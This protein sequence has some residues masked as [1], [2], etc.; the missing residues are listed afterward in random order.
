MGIQDR[1]ETI[2]RLVAAVPSRA[3]VFERLGIDYC[4]G[5]H[6]HLD[7]VAR[8]RGIDLDALVRDVEAADGEPREGAD[9]RVASDEAL[10]A[11]ILDVHHRYLQAELP[12]LGALVH[13]VERVHGERHPEL[14]EVRR[15]YDALAGDLIPHMQKE[16]Q[17]LFP[18]MQ[19]LRAG[20]IHAAGHCGGIANPLRVMHREHGDAGLALARLRALTRGYAVPED[21]C[22]SYRAMLAR[23]ERLEQDTHEHIHEEENVLFPRYAQ[24][25]RS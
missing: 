10:I 20:E 4:C 15:I 1:H 16:E 14:A 12:A 18:M 9:W 6:R 21:A 7:E 3:R 25:S 5:G 19:R 2:G 8:E 22:T 17:V 13:K 11:H 23:L 24:E